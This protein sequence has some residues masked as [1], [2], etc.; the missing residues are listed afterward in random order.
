MSDSV[1][2][3]LIRGI[4]AAKGNSKQEAK[5]YLEWVTRL[6][7]ASR[8]ELNEAFRYLALMADDPKD[9]REYLEHALAYNP[10]DPEAR[11]ALALLN[12]TLKPDEIIDPNKFS[13]PASV[14]PVPTQVRRFV[15][16]QCG[17]KM[18]FAPDATTLECTYCGFKQSLL[19]LNQS[20]PIIEEHDFIVAMAT[21]KGH[22]KP[23]IARTIKCKGCGAS[24][25]LAPQTLSQNCPYCASAYVIE[26]AEERELI[27]PEG[28]MPF[29]ITR[30]AALKK[31]MEWFR[32]RGWRLRADPAP[33][34][35]VY[36]PAWTFD[37][38]GEVTWTCR[39]YHNK[40]WVVESG[41]RA[42][43]ANDVLV[44]ASHRLSKI[45]SDEILH[46]SL[47]HLVP[48]DARY[49]ADFPAETYEIAVSDASIVARSHA[50]H[51]VKAEIA[52]GIFSQYADLNVSSANVMVD[53]YK[54]I[55]VPMWITHYRMEG[56][57]YGIVINGYTGNLRAEQPRQG[58][59]GWLTHWFGA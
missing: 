32:Q 39:I 30:D 25:I 13:Q 18:Q 19:D 53:S 26:Q 10:S 37:V 11:R 34:A 6:P 38:G 59:M 46:T 3:L 33:P 24:F 22:S 40:Q 15:C 1:R 52:R 4:A 48:Y 43:L 55:L 17:G 57:Q 47:D 9:K 50:F 54:L 45:L 44:P 35:G 7:D 41:N 20:L 2:D 51:H 29:M 16:A 23:T 58:V 36:L 14:S 21:A 12:G 8:D 5:F 42:V 31:E 56:E 27:E 49:L 28:I